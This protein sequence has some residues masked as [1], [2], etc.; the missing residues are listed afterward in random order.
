MS[1]DIFGIISADLAI[2]YKNHDSRL[3]SLQIVNDSMILS[4]LWKIED[5][6][7]TIYTFMTRYIEN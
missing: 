6:N 7:V 1:G 5:S 2:F 4:Q 3:F